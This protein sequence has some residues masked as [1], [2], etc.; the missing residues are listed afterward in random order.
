MNLTEAWAA[1]DLYQGDIVSPVKGKPDKTMVWGEEPLTV[2]ERWE[3]EGA[4]GLHVIDLDAALETGSNSVIVESIIHHVKV[5]VQI[6]G[7]IRNAVDV[8]MWLERGADRVVIGTLAYDDPSTLRQLLRTYGPE[9][10]VIATDYAD[11]GMVVTRG[12]KRKESIG[13]FEAVKRFEAM[14]VKTLL[15]TAVELDGTARGPDIATLRSIRN[16]TRMCILASGGVR[17]VGDIRELQHI[18]V[19]G[20]VLGRALYEGTVHLAELNLGEA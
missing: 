18:G 10:I 1:V 15:A 11:A 20:V 3:R 13:V 17:T 14:R 2:A 4:T 7:G 6:G 5:P 16:S 12:W 19:D 8:Q 9:S